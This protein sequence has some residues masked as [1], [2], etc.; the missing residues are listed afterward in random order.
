MAL[1]FRGS[2]VGFLKLGIPQNDFSEAQRLGG[3]R[4]AV[5]ALVEALGVADP[6]SPRVLPIAVAAAL[7]AVV[8]AE[9]LEL[10]I[11]TLNGPAADNLSR[12]SV[13]AERSL[14]P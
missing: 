4:D 7:A 2:C 14:F 8:G 3:L 9:A 1:R 11:E 12:R 13:R 6:G 5:V 10:A